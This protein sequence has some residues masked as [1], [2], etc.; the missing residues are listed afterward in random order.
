MPATAAA[1]TPA[2]MPTSAP[3][4]IATID[5]PIAMSTIRPC[6]SAKWLGASRQP[7]APKKYGSEKSS[8][9]ASAQSAPCCQPSAAAAA[10]SRPTPTAVPPPS[11]MTDRRSIGSS[12]LASTKSPMWATRTAP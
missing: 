8:T 12:W 11:P 9:M 4:P 5:S 6:R 2:P 3:T 10:I 1:T 7:S